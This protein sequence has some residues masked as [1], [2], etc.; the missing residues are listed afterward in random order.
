MKD[1]KLPYEERPETT[2]EYAQRIALEYLRKRDAMKARRNQLTW[3][4]LGV[5]AAAVAPF[6]FGTGSAK[7]VF[8]NAPLSRS[9]SV[10]E[11]GCNQCHVAAFPSVPDTACEQCHA[12]PDHP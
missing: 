1:E 4:A 7:K 5:C 3:I 2:K 6:L 12:G 10:F 8:S 9:H 11:S